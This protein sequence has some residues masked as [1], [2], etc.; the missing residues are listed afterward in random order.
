M[1]HTLTCQPATGF[2]IEVVF[3]KGHLDT[4]MEMDNGLGRSWLGW[5]GRGVGGSGVIVHTFLSGVR[6]AWP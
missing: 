1:I 3:L 2:E 5:R 6:G 4:R